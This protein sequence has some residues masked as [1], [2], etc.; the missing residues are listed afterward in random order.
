VE[1]D[2]PESRRGHTNAPEPRPISPHHPVNE[3]NGDVTPAI[4]GGF[5]ERQTTRYL[6]RIVSNH[7]TV[8]NGSMESILQEPFE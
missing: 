6:K 5:P 2:E 7:A 3:Q 4:E 1:S 8:S